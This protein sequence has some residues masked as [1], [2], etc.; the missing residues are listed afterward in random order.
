[1][2]AQRQPFRP[3]TATAKGRLIELEGQ[4]VYV[5]QFPSPTDFVFEYFCDI[6]AVFRLLPDTLDVQ[7]YGPDRYRL[8]VGATDG[9]G[10]SMSAIFDLA[11]Y[12]QPGRLIQVV[13]ANDGPLT[14]IPGLVFHGNLWAEAIFEPRD[15]G[16]QVEYTVTIDLDIPIPGVLSL[17]PFQFLQNLGEKAMAFKMTQM[18]NGFARDIHADFRAWAAGN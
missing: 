4:A 1:M 9:H 14:R 2:T 11:A 13:P 18:I 10:H 5:F 15:Y 7:T 3:L 17:M 6:P 8:V 16:S 12:L